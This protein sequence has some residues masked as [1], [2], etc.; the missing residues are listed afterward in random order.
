MSEF[1]NPNDPR[2]TPYD[3]NVRQG[4]ATWGWIAGA[5]FVVV[6]VALAFGIGRNPNQTGTN[7]AANN[8]PMTEPSP[9]PSGPA[10]S[11]FSPAPMN[12]AN[13]APMTPAQPQPKP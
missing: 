13:P 2:D 11:A 9:V 5:V 1:R 3:P 6:L 10:G 7:V 4:G 12:P 8:P